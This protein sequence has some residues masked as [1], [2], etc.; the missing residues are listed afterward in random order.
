MNSQLRWAQWKN[1]L[2]I[3]DLNSCYDTEKE[4]IKMMH[5]LIHDILKRHLNVTQPTNHI[6]PL[7]TFI[8][9]VDHELD[10]L[11]YYI[12]IA[13]LVRLLHIMT[14]FPTNDEKIA[15]AKIAKQRIEFIKKLFV[16]MDS[17]P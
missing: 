14:I 3:D 2:S 17:H 6:S 10:L 11:N 4:R 8:K 13:Q 16:A 12:R 5:T 9:A 7:V 15:K 1:H